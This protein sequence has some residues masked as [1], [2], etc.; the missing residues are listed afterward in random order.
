MAVTPT[1][2]KL[3]KSASNFGGAISATEVSGSN[4][5]GTFSGAETAA[6]RTEFACL[7]VR[8]TSGQTAFGVKVWINAET[9]HGSVNAQIALGNAAINASETATA[10]ETTAP[11]PALTFTEAANEAAA[12]NIGDL[13]ANAF[14]AVW[15]RLA[16][17]AGTPA[18]NTY[19]I[20]LAIKAETGE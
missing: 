13:A 10:N 2:L 19:Q 6:G 14:K 11:A 12:L 15:I 9:V 18:K 16:V 5:F 17:P 8:N 4:V 3:F 20:E 7:Y 1:D